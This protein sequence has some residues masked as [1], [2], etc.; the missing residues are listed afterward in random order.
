MPAQHEEEYIGL[1][2]AKMCK[3]AEVAADSMP[4]SALKQLLQQALLLGC[5]RSFRGLCKCFVQR[6]GY[7]DMAQVLLSIST[8]DG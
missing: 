8:H 1:S 2:V 4:S 7:A 3:E 5:G 6:L